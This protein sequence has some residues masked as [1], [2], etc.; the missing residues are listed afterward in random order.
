MK[1]KLMQIME[2]PDRRYGV[3]PIIHHNVLKDELIQQMDDD[4]FAGVVANIEYRRHFDIDDT[5]WKETAANIREYIKRG[6][7]VW[8]YDEDGYPS[9]VASGYLTEKYPEHIAK[10]LYCY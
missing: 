9:S 4:G 3:Y 7:H 8:L 6:M 10:G 1:E 2:N 5:V